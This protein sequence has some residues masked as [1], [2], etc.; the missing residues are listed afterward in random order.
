MI[1]RDFCRL[2]A[3]VWKGRKCIAF[4]NE[5]AVFGFHN[6]FSFMSPPQLFRSKKMQVSEHIL[7]LFPFHFSARF[8]QSRAKAPGWKS[9]VRRSAGVGS[10]HFCLFSCREPPVSGCK[11]LSLL[12]FQRNVIRIV[13]RKHPSLHIRSGSDPR[14][15]AP[16]IH[17]IPAH[18]SS[19]HYRRTE[20]GAACTASRP[21]L[22]FPR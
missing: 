19:R 16:D 10:G 8:R 4:M 3:P 20:T 21:A 15:C 11:L 5:R 22:P 14:Y 13:C 12:A 1:L 18:R 17:S 6:Y 7:H 9:T 2:I